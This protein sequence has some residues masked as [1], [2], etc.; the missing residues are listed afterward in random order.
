MDIFFVETTTA[1]TAII[2]YYS[3]LLFLVI[4]SRMHAVRIIQETLCYD[5]YY[6]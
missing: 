1:S 3:I 5:Y 6:R 4:P 2:V